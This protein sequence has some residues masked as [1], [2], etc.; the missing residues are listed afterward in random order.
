MKRTF[1]NILLITFIIFNIFFPREIL[2]EKIIA[3]Y[4]NKSLISR[5]KSIVSCVN[6][7]NKKAL[8]NEVPILAYHNIAPWPQHSTELF[9][10]LTVRVDE[11]NAQMLYLFNSGYTPITLKEL[12]LIWNKKKQMPT[13]PLILTF[14]AGY[15]NVFCYA[16][17]TLRKYK[18]KFVIFPITKYLFIDTSMYLSPE[19]IREML[20]SGLVEVGS[21][22]RDHIDLKK[23]PN[24]IVYF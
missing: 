8:L 12:D 11:F 21:H 22:T 6:A 2:K 16:F 23:V 10:S 7:Q 4:S 1:K 20:K 15:S 13:K 19:E 18:F 17:P 9:K 5:T 24:S 3:C 14:D